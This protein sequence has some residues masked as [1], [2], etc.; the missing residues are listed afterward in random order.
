MVNTW[1]DH[2]D[3][4]DAVQA[5][6]AGGV[7]AYPTEGVWG[8]GCLPEN[9]RAVQ[10]ILALKGRSED[11]GL[12]LVAAELNQV[13]PMLATLNSDQLAVLQG[14]WP[15]PN[16]WLVPHANRV[17]RWITGR[18]DKVALRVSDHPVVQALSTLVGS[19]IVST[20]ANPQG[21][22]AAM[23]ASEVMTYFAGQLDAVAP[24]DVGARGRPSVIRD[25]LTGVEVRP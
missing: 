13:I 1:L 9:Q 2:P 8:L 4:A 12:I 15:G 11:K 25:L 16:T 3:V 23:S 17:P 19:A 5:L 21:L 18:H 7:I 10:K 20:S 14:S 6:R 24:G 22:P